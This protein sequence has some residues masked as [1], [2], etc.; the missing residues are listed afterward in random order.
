MDKN[1][2]ISKKD[3]AKL[4]SQWSQQFSVFLP[5]RESGMA[6]MAEWDGKDTTRSHHEGNE[7]WR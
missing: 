3:I 7:L 1:K 6:T 2:R 4:L 5:S